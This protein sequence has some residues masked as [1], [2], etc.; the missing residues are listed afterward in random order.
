MANP[1]DQSASG[2]LGGADQQNGPVF[3]IDVGLSLIM[4]SNMSFLDDKNAF[5]NHACVR[6]RI[7]PV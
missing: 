4:V 5:H 1:L 3:E 2:L 6:F 7:A